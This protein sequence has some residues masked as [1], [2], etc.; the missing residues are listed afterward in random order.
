MTSDLETQIRAIL[1]QSDS[2]GSIPVKRTA[3]DGTVHEYR[4]SW[5]AGFGS[6]LTRAAYV[7]KFKEQPPAWVRILHPAKEASIYNIALKAG[8]PLS[9]SIGDVQNMT[10][11]AKQAS[12]RARDFAVAAH[13]DQPYGDLPYV[14]HLAA[15]VR[16]LGDFGF[17]GDYLIA[18]WLHDVVEDTDKT[19]AEIESAFGDRASKLVWAVTGGGERATHVATIHQKIADYP[20]AAAVKLADRIANVEACK[21]GD[22][23]SIRY[24]REH[25]EFATVIQPHVPAAMWQRYLQALFACRAS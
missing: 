19:V 16:V 24:N 4:C 15:V 9:A 3:S 17:A 22:K 10:D 5:I 11:N 23:H 25:A 7:Q 18:G 21:A 20:D 8:T 14:A 2:G 13:G 12:D 6:T 1:K